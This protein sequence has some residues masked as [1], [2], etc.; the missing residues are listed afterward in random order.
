MLY[1]DIGVD[2]NGD[3]DILVPR[4]TELPHE[5]TCRV[6][7]NDINLLSLYEG[8]YVETTMNHMLGLYTLENSRDGYF[9][10]GLRIDASYEMTITIDDRLL[11]TVKCSQEP[12]PVPLEERRIWLNARN[13]F[14][15]FIQS[16][17]LFVK[18]PLTKK[19]LPEWQ[20]V[21]EKLEWANQIM[22]Y[23]V[24]AEEYTMA[25]QEIE[26]IV[27]PHLQKTYHKKAFEKSPLL[28]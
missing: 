16:T 23:E 5:F 10:L 7:M 19:N 26:G 21:L 14:R 1:Q 12:N 9:T 2:Q 8:N 25:L 20:W 18:D 28:E 24:S 6:K 22:E 27:N 15:D 4:D 17:I 3:M 11:D 13:E